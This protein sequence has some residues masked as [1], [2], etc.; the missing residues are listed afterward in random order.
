M[1]KDRRVGRDAHTFAEEKMLTV[2][3]VAARLH[4]SLSN[5]HAFVGV[6]GGFLFGSLTAALL[7]GFDQ[8]HGG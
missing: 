2:K 1:K 5:A 3:Q 8:P 6:G 4:C 7:I